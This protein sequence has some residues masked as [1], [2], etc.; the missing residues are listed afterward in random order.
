MWL[1]LEHYQIEA[2][3]GLANAAPSGEYSGGHAL[4]TFLLLTG[5][6]SFPS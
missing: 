4:G 5:N 1:Y 6:H 2:H 3:N